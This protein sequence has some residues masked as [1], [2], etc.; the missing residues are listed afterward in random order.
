MNH[1]KYQDWLLAL[2]GLPTAAGC[3]QRVIDWVR[4]WAKRRRGVTLRA[5]RHG[6][7]LL[8]R[9]PRPQRNT[10]AKGKPIYFT[11]HMDHPAFVVTQITGPREIEATFRGG[12]GR[13]FFAG[14]RVLLHQ[15]GGGDGHDD[16]KTRRGTVRRLL[17]TKNG[18][19][20]RHAVITFP[21]KLSGAATGQ[22]IT[23]DTGTA[24]ISRDRLFAPACDDLA[25]VAAAL[26]A[27]DALGGRGKSDVRV[28]LTRA[29]EVGF[30][31]AIGACSSGII[32]K[33]ARVV[34][35]ECSKSFAHDSPIGGGPIVRVGDRTS[36]FD[37]GLTTRLCKIAGHIAATEDSFNWQRC[38]MP[39]GTCEATAYQ[40]YGY[41]AACLCLPLGNYHNMDEAQG[42]I[43][44]ETISMA[45]FHGLVRL[46]VAIGRSLDD[47][48][49]DANLRV[50][51]DTLFA[52]RRGLL[53]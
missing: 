15:D 46:L 32:P 6:N 35:L 31:G 30:I 25:G 49:H 38:L 4:R 45:D 33:R 47:A 27:F 12:V 52:Q 28:L 10:R 2:T 39:G 40:A 16:K 53:V 5:D 22:I 42:K 34:A 14:A 48:A 44:P 1:R 17:P 13:Q 19:S 51:L 7:L 9:P 3:E 26:A 23:W 43:G 18:E 20:D 50:R 21:H 41:T 29:E 36:T 11:A 24:R 37:P 8:T